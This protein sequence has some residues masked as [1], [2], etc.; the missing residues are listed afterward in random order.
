[1]ILACF[2]EAA[3]WKVSTRMV[4]VRIFF[5]SRVPLPG[6]NCRQGVEIKLM[7]ESSQYDTD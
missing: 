4:V 5:H 6:S 7:S 3:G 2:Q 1:M